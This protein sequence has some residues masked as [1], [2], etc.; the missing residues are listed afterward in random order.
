MTEPILVWAILSPT[1]RTPWIVPSSIRPTREEAIKSVF[2][3]EHWRSYRR[4][5]FRAIRVTVRFD[6]E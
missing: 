2:G 6:A 1:G 4:K 5:G 3:M